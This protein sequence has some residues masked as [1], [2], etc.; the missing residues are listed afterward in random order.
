[1][2]LCIITFT[3]RSSHSHVKV[4]N[5]AFSNVSK[6]GRSSNQPV[7]VKIQQGPEMYIYEKTISLIDIQKGEEETRIPKFK[8][9]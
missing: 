4:D 7:E 9:A 3:Q 2:M 8:E 5:T 6:K 1:M